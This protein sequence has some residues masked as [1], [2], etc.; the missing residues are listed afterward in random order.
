MIRRQQHQLKWKEV[1]LNDALKAQRK[2]DEQEE[3]NMARLRQEVAGLTSELEGIRR[4]REARESLSL[5]EREA[6]RVRTTAVHA[7]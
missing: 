5:C 3:A 7:S 6:K 4:E 2:R 1:K